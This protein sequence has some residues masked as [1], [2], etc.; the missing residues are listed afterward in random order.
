[1]IIYSFYIFFS[2]K[3][4]CEQHSYEEFKTA[5]EAYIVCCNEHR[6]KR[7]LIGSVL[8]S[9]V[10]NLSPHSKKRRKLLSYAFRSSYL[11][12]LQHDG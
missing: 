8:L 3:E 4:V 9:I 1:M 5:I 2:D 7:I 6:V 11:G 12:S 10:A